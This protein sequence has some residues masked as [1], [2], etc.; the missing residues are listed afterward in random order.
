MNRSPIPINLAWCC[1][2]RAAFPRIATL[3]QGW[4]QCQRGSL[5][6]CAELSPAGVH[7]SLHTASK[8]Q[9]FVKSSAVS[10]S[11]CRRFNTRFVNECAKQSK[12]GELH[13]GEQK[14]S[15]RSNNLCLLFL[16]LNPAIINAQGEHLTTDCVISGAQWEH[17]SEIPVGA[18]IQ[19]PPAS[20][21]EMEK[22]IQVKN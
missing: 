13:T 6:L 5:V 17:R 8:I 15:A 11:A 16:K 20:A 2:R 10:P 4:W 9:I 12:R 3:Y 19:T 14:S 18:F 7:H 21:A 1:R 22:T